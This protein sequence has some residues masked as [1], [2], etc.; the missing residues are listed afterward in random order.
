MQPSVASARPAPSDGPM[1][2]SSPVPVQTWTG[3]SPVP[4][5]M[6]HT[7]DPP[8]LA[9]MREAGCA[10]VADAHTR[11]CTCPQPVGMKRVSERTVLP[12]NVQSPSP[13]CGRAS[14]CAQVLV[15]WVVRAGE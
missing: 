1:Q 2:A 5:E 3:A 7:G 8:V 10:V 14:E 12:L 6:W 13:V 11:S 9:Q 4:V 15:G